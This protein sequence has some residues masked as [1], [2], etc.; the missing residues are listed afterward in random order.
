M[1]LALSNLTYVLIGWF[2]FL[3]L[4]F[5]YEYGPCTSLFILYVPGCFLNSVERER[6]MNWIIS[7]MSNNDHY[8]YT[9][10][11]SVGIELWPMTLKSHRIQT[12]SLMQLSTPFLRLGLCYIISPEVF[13]FLKG[14]YDIYSLKGL[15]CPL[16][17]TAQGDTGVIDRH[18][19][20]V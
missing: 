12:K 15:F 11:L 19:H 16:W 1:L 9:L 18:W 7:T 5:L 20:T 8:R 2:K 10:L 14:K 13:Y 3:L 17:F 4:M 6:Q